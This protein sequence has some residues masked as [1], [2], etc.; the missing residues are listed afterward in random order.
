MRRRRAYIAILNHILEP[1][2][3][4]RRSS[5]PMPPSLVIDP[6]PFVESLQ[7]H[8]A[9]EPNGEHGPELRFNPDLDLWDE[10]NLRHLHETRV[11]SIPHPHGTAY[12]EYLHFR[13][14]ASSPVMY[15]VL[16]Q[17]LLYQSDVARVGN[18]VSV[19]AT[20]NALEFAS[21]VFAALRTGPGPSANRSCAGMM[22]FWG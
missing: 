16:R 2:H 18:E 20:E 1:L 13:V 5:H 10:A 9:F 15:E 17:G 22:S 19:Y 21:E 14:H 8:A 4:L 11:F 12:H 3:T 6:G 7:Q